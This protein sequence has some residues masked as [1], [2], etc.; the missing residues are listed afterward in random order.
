LPAAGDR[1]ESPARVK[2]ILKLNDGTEVGVDFVMVER[3]D[4][5][6]VVDI[7]A[8]GVSYVR[9]YRSQFRVDIAGDGL[10]SVI[11]WLQGKAARTAAE[12]QRPE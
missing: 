9:T 7:V 3:G 1:D 10:D 8:E 5:W 12:A 4:S 2:T 11:V 6:R